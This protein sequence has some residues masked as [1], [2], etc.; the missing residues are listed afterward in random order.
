[1][2][3]L[4]PISVGELVDKITIL[5]IKRQRLAAA[6][7]LANVERELAKLETLMAGLP[8]DEAFLDL[9]E[10]LEAVNATLWDIEELKR[11]HE[12]EGRFDD[13]FIDLSRQVYLRNDDRA[14]IKRRL[15][16]RAGS[17]IIEEKSYG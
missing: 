5:R 11:T 14:A 8:Q 17:S 4:A 6:D 9:V 15:N 13:A 3:I 1:M 7:K 2:E 12:R 16:L 10:Q